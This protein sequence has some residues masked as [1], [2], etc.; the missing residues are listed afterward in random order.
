ML[1]VMAASVVRRRRYST[2]PDDGAPEARRALLRLDQEVS[3]AILGPAR[4][5]VIGAEGPFLAVGDDAQAALR[6]SL[7]DQIVHGRPGA[8]LAQREVVLVGAPLVAM[9]LDEHQHGGVALQPR[10]VGVRRLGVGRPDLVLVEVEVAVL[11]LGARPEGARLR[12]GRRRHGP[13]DRAATARAAGT[14]ATAATADG[15]PGPTAEARGAARR[16]RRRHR[17]RRSLGAAGGRQDQ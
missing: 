9:A 6:H 4:L 7:T 17:R 10:R 15:A 11:Q 16:R 1:M 8:A 3:A 5:V 12:A 13:V 14:A 2:R